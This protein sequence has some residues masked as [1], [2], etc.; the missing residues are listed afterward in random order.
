VIGKSGYE[1][2]SKKGY[3]I[4]HMEMEK[5]PHSILLSNSACDK[6]VESKEGKKGKSYFLNNKYIK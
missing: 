6:Q 2:Q 1:R 5:K 3:F 4:D